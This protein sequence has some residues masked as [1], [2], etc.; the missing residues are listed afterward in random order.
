[1][2][3]RLGRCAL[4]GAVVTLITALA[5]LTAGADD[6]A[7]AFSSFASGTAYGALRLRTEHVEQD[8]RAKNAIAH[9]ARTRLGYAS[10]RWRDT[11]IQIELENTTAFGAERFNDGTDPPGRRPTIPDPDSTEVN[12]AALRYEGLAA[13]ELILG[14]RRIVLDNERFIA[15][16]AFRQNQQT[17][18]GGSIVNRGLPLTELRYDYVSGVQRP[19]GYDADDG[20]FN[21][22]GHLFH[23]SFRGLA[24]TL[25]AA[26]G[27]A[28]DVDDDPTL[29]S[30]T[31]GVRLTGD[32]PLGGNWAATFDL[33]VAR[34]TD[35][36]DNPRDFDLAYYLVRPGVAHR[37]FE[38][39]VGYE[40]LDGD[41]RQAVQTPFGNL[42]KFQGFADIFAITPAVGIVDRHVGF[43]W[44][45]PKF[46][47]LDS[48]RIWGAYHD[49]EARAGG[50]DLGTELDLAVAASFERRYTLT[51]KWARYDA[52]QFATDTAK[53]W[54]MLEVSF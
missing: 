16:A 25:L 18:D 39:W 45:R 49:F 17:F 47:G 48:L 15:D 9:T 41:R 51:A 50:A 54:L 36:A 23:V 30:R 4:W 29:S 2:H 7:A 11:S 46:L 26:Y 3:R 34:Q 35:Y 6:L 28:F 22:A 31:L 27:Y 40:V 8:A 52:A 20:T 32:R 44:K 12:Q 43:D 14:R 10:G 37:G 5:P 13:T 53:I 24:R 33:D 38:A 1:M 21:T 42:H 19:S